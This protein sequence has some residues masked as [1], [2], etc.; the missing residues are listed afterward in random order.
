M[1][2]YYNFYFLF[3]CGILV[4]QPG[5]ELGPQLWKLRRS[6]WTNREFSIVFKSVIKYILLT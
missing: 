6:H 5:T 4:S 3:G 1:S 2:L